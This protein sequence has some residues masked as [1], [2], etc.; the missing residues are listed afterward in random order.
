MQSIALSSG[1]KLLRPADRSGHLYFVESGELALYRGQSSAPGVELDRLTAGHFLGELELFEGGEPVVVVAATDAQVRR[2]PHARL[3]RLKEDRSAEATA[4]ILPEI[5]RRLQRQRF[6]QAL[7]AVFPTLTGEVLQPLMLVV[8]TESLTSGEVLFAEGS[9]ATDVYFVVSG[10]LSIRITGDNG[11]RVIGEASR[12]DVV[13]EFALF[14]PGPR[15]ATVVATRDAEL[16]RLSRADFDRLIESFPSLVVAVTKKMVQRVRTGNRGPGGSR[17]RR[18]MT[19]TVVEAGDRAVA[20]EF[21]RKLAEALSRFGSALELT[22]E[23]FNRESGQPRAAE[24]TVTD[25][26]N[27]MVVSVLSEIE[28]EHRFVVYVADAE[29][30]EWT[31]RCL[32]SSDRVL[33]IADADARPTPSPLERAATQFATEAR[34]E[35]VLLQPAE[36]DRPRRTGDW[37]APRNV[38]EH[39]HVQRGNA[40]HV[41]RVARRLAGRA[42]GLVLGGG[43]ARGYAH[44]GVW[45]ALEE[46][47]VDVDYIGG[48]SMGALLAAAFAM[49]LSYEE[50]VEQS[51]TV[52]NPKSLFDYTLP[53]AALMASRKLNRLCHRIYG[54]L[55]VEDLW[56]PYFSVATNLSTAEQIIFRKGP[57]WRAVRCSISIPGVF[58][59]VVERG[60]IIVDGAVMNNFPVDLMQRYVESDSIIAVNV[61]VPRDDEQEYDFNYEVS[62]W[63]LLFN[64]INPFARR[65]LN[66]PAIIGTLVRTMEVNSVRHTLTA[67]TEAR[68]LLEPNMRSIGLLEFDRFQQAA[69][70]GYQ[71]SLESIRQW[72]AQDDERTKLRVDLGEATP[73]AA[74]P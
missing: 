43:G 36:R 8:G 40:D 9:E 56:V 24:T 35:L 68:L 46:L 54:Q 57:L 3:L 12:G 69:D 13:G 59:P 26:L 14:S 51:R 71:N 21:A 55:Q 67:R 20:L 70:L 7:R 6:A 32:R 65:R 25:P 33:L 28:S 2:L 11:I 44:L 1:D 30:N 4:S 5:E 64:R 27:S 53:F 72:L 16:L 37:L 74:L 49:G 31:R 61:S 50:V 63:R 58:A 47:D 45:R 42:L 66:F 15:S 48:T 62:G 18:T 60:E 52:A 73:T 22:S 23:T 10:R 41:A 38:A 29:M 39:H 19:V 17:S 34:V